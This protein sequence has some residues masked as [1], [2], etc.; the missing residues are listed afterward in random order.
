VAGR[1][2]PITAADKAVAEAKRVDRLTLVKQILRLETNMRAN[3]NVRKSSA[4]MAKCYSSFNFEPRVHRTCVS[5]IAWLTA[6]LSLAKIEAAVPY[7]MPSIV[8]LSK[9]YAGYMAL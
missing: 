3:I 2:S 6:A 5:A 8:F 7:D 4:L 1:H 9:A